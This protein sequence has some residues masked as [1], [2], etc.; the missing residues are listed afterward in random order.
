[1]KPDELIT[2]VVDY[3]VKHVN[4]IGAAIAGYTGYAASVLAGSAKAKGTDDFWSFIDPELL[5]KME[6]V[7]W[8]LLAS[9]GACCV[10]WFFDW[11]R[12]KVGFDKEKIK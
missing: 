8:G 6:N 1:M 10:K 11:L 3:F 7:L 9:A 4:D 2:K 5:G 12:R